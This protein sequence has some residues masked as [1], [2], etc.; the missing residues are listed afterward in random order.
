MKDNAVNYSELM[1]YP[2]LIGI[3]GASGGIYA[4]NLI[5]KLIDLGK[6]V[7]LIVT[8]TGEAVLKH[9]SMSKLLELGLK[10]YK[11]EDFFAK[12]ASGSSLYY[13]MVVVP[14]SMGT[15]GRIASGTADNLLVRSAD[16]FLKEKRKL[17]I[18]ARETPYNAIHLENMLKLDRAGATIIPASPSF[19]TKPQT[20]DD[21]VNTVVERIVSQLYPDAP[22]IKHWTSNDD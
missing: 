5:K 4:Y 3:T 9:E 1:K 17:I 18:V 7:E 14:S 2:I 10:R 11:I 19:Y 20:V 21:V 16:V 12:P 22:G 15:I 8:K 6:D 13:A